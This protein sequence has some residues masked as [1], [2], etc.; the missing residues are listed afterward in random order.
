MTATS[1][2]PK[3]R[4]RL[5]LSSMEVLGFI[6]T[7]GKAMR[8][9]I[10]RLHPPDKPA[11]STDERSLDTLAD[12][13]P[14]EFGSRVLHRNLRWGLLLTVVSVVVILAGV[15]LWLHQRP[16]QLAQQAVADVSAAALALQPELEALAES[17]QALAD[18]TQEVDSPTAILLTIDTL[19]RDLF[20]I[21]ASLPPSE[22]TRRA[23][24][25]DAASEALAASRLIADAHAYQAAVLPIL[26]LPALETD[27]SLISLDEAAERFG[28]WHARFDSVR[29]ALPSDVMQEVTTEL[30]TISARLQNILSRYLDALR[31]DQQPAAAAVVQ[32]LSDDLSHVEKLLANSISE[33][34]DRAATRIASSLERIELLLG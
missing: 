8:P 25:A 23:H 20:A 10:H 17:N 12:W 4:R 21:S 7:P 27:P 32:D 18:P 1:K 16:A 22:A 14:E 9:P 15:A 29:S 31:Q 13:K 19:A 5:R 28:D 11:A 24:A 33:V 30:G 26:T 3:P 2:P 6:D 34:Q